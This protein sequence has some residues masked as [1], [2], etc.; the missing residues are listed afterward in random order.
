MRGE[1]GSIRTTVRRGEQ[2]EYTYIVDHSLLNAKLIRVIE[3]EGRVSRASSGARFEVRRLSDVELRSWIY[4]LLT[5]WWAL[6]L[7]LSAS[8]V[9]VQIEWSD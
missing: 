7:G 3:L 6:P 9:F 5:N 1:E 4:D 2:M 8:D